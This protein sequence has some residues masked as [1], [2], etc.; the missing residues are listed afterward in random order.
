M[1]SMRCRLPALL[2]VVGLLFVVCDL[3]GAE[4]PSSPEILTWIGGIRDINA[5]VVNGT[6]NDHPEAREAASTVYDPTNKIMWLFGGRPR[7]S[8]T[9]AKEKFSLL[10]IIIFKNSHRLF[11]DRLSWRFVGLLRHI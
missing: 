10:F 11:L 3:C 8:S 1:K 2:A 7:R 4:A 5:N 6:L 9:S